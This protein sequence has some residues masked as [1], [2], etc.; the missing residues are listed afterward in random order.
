M[1]SL[2][3]HLISALL[4]FLFACNRTRE[5]LAEANSQTNTYKK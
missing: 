5:D 4:D 3:H 1:K 2:F